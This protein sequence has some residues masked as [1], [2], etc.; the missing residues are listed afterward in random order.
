MERIFVMLF[1]DP[2]EAFGAVSELSKNGLGRDVTS[3]VAND[4][5]LNR[6]PDVY[7]GNL[8]GVSGMGRSVSLPGIG[9]VSAI[10]PL[11]TDIRNTMDSG[12]TDM[13]LVMTLTK[14]GVSEEYAHAFVEGVR[15]GG[16]LVTVASV[17]TSQT[18]ARDILNR[19]NPVDIRGV[20]SEWNQAGWTRFDASSQPLAVHELD[21]P[22][23]ITTRP[24]EEGS[25]E[26]SENWPQDIAARGKDKFEKEET[27]SNWPENIADSEEKSENTDEGTNWPRNIAS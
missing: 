8:E 22:Q 15:R 13:P 4:A 10:G 2:A 1:E 6:V 19:H 21:W 24:G 5:A 12:V 27:S 11:A 26:S 16:T 23:S 18:L 25:Q 9:S 14:E 20:K 3:L 17:E 7:F